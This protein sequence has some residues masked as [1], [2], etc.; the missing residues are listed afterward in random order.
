MN[1]G[2]CCRVSLKAK[3]KL[4]ELGFDV[5][6]AFAPVEIPNE[7]LG[8]FKSCRGSDG[9]E[10]LYT[11]AEFREE[12]LDNA[13][14]RI[15]KKACEVFGLDASSGKFVDSG[16]ILTDG[17]SCTGHWYEYEYPVAGTAGNM[18]KSRSVVFKVNDGYVM[19]GRHTGPLRENPEWSC[20]GLPNDFSFLALSLVAS[21]GADGCPVAVFFP[22]SDCL[23]FFTFPT[24]PGTYD[25]GVIVFDEKNAAGGRFALFYGGY[26]MA[27]DLNVVTD[28]QLREFYRDDAELKRS[29]KKDGLQQKVE[30][31]LWFTGIP[32]S[33]VD[34]SF[35]RDTVMAKALYYRNI[36]E[37]EPYDFVQARYRE[38]ADFWEK[39]AE[40]KPVSEREKSRCGFEHKLTPIDQFVKWRYGLERA[41]NEEYKQYFKSRIEDLKEFVS[42]EFSEIQEDVVQN[43]SAVPE[44]SVSDDD[45]YSR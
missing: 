1:K 17:G 42:Q 12:K 41:E 18:A 30:H 24:G 22:S 2:L 27:L 36:A 11:E 25:G 20:E 16:T 39:V 43:E 26:D 19:E 3:A 8:L 5:S 14:N 10:E 29:Y 15:E 38:K 21:F 44:Q 23:S 35:V 32:G 40:G 9:F 28:E 37:K 7:H 6:E 45:G 13:F 34:M 33:Q 31:L 4:R